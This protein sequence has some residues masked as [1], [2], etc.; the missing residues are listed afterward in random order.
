MIK[1]LTPGQPVPP[2]VAWPTLAVCGL[3]AVLSGFSMQAHLLAAGDIGGALGLSADEASWVPTA[4]AAAE[5]AAVLLAAPLT[6]AFGPR[7]IVIIG[8]LTTGLLA[9]LGLAFPQ[10]L[11]LIRFMQGFACGMLPVVMMIWAMRAF[12]PNNRGLP[13]ML[14][15]FASSFPSAFAGLIV[16]H[17]TDHWG[18]T[19]PFILD[20]LWTPLVLLAAFHVLPI[21]EARS[22]NLKSQD[23]L[24]FVLLA[25]GVMLIIVW[26]QQGER[27][28]WLETF[29]TAPLIAAGFALFALAIARLLAATTP[30]LDLTLLRRTTFAFGMAEALSLRFGLLMASFAVPQALMR[31]QGFRAEQSGQAVLWLALGQFIGFPLAW[32]WLRRLDARWPLAAGLATFTLAALWAA[33]ITPFWQIDQFIGPMVLAGFGQGLF[34]TSVMNFATWGVPATAGATAAGLFNL[35][36]VLGTSMASA[37][38]GF[39]LRI[40]ENG[41]SAILTEGITSANEAVNI[42]LEDLSRSYIAITPDAAAAQSASLAALV[43]QVSAQAY[44]LA[45]GDIFLA[46]AAVLTVSVLLVP[47]LPRLDASPAPPV[48]AGQS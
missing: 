5:G 35:V 15:A 40:R 39:A 4:G 14:F 30:W 45:F 43:K 48:S 34:L 42:R 2:V 3:A 21:E 47:L 1:I 8:A 33:Q 7:R 36:R 38:V 17:A 29:W 32:L 12:P 24:G 20:L 6:G 11:I 25:A 41:H 31:L 46:I 37:A 28:F 19:G 9:V 16:G 22:K 44:T 27:R 13:L 23:W 26:L 18:G 10:Q